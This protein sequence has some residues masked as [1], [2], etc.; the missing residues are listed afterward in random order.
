VTLSL[1]VLRAS[2]PVVFLF[3]V[4]CATASQVT[5]DPGVSPAPS[6]TPPVG[7][8]DV[9]PAPCPTAG[10]TL[11]AGFCATIFADSVGSARHLV[12]AAN[13]DV[14][15]AIQ[16]GRPNTYA[17]G[18][19]PGVLALR[20]TNGDGVADMQ[21]RFAD[22]GNT[23]IGLYDGH[24]YLDI[25]TAILR[26]P[27]PGG[28]LVP[29]GPPDTVVADVPSLPGH[30]ARNFVIA[31]DGTLFMNSGSATNACQVQER[32]QES[33]GRDPCVELETRA[34]IW[35]FDARATGQRFTPAA[36]YATGIRNATGM[37]LHP[38]TGALYAASHGRDLLSGNWP[39]YFTPEQNAE[40]PAEE[41]I[42]VEQGDH[43]GWPYCYWDGF[44]RTR[45]LA[46]EYGGNGRIIG[47][48]TRYKGTA[49]ALPAHWAPNSLTFY[50]GRAFPERYHNGAFIAFH[51]SWNRAPLR[52]EGYNVVFIPFTGGSTTGAWEVFANGFGG[53]NPTPTTAPHRPSGVAIGPDGALYVGD[54]V[55]GRIWKITYSGN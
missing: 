41:F 18:I 17:A 4:A 36:R 48:C 42:H 31:S 19:R 8:A 7:V 35:R 52:Q 49:S 20:D 55:G 6:E 23:G 53:A 46:P 54:D 37:A 28:E 44:H 51:G 32:Q 33:P 40:L 11:P 25:G 39:A 29:S 27:L 2:L 43:F 9:A 10:L 22:T 21:R 47:R 1:V 26:Y 45:M 30:R 5:V 34:G 38:L 50:N 13:G 12:V 15:V 16:R 24:L 3:G 14:F